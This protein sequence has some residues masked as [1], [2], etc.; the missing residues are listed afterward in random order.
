MGIISKNTNLSLAEHERWENLSDI[1]QKIESKKMQV[2]AAMIDRID[3]NIGRLLD[4]LKSKGELDNT[5]ILFA[6]DNGGSSENAEKE[7]NNVGPI[8]S[9]TNWK[10]LKKNWANVSNTPYRNYK[11]WSHE[12]GIKTPLIAY[13]PNGIKYTNS[14]IK[15]P[16]H[17]IDI[18]PTFS[19]IIDVPYPEEYNSKKIIPT[20]GK[21]FWGYLNDKDEGQRIDPL[22]WEWQHGKAV[23]L[24][25]WKLVSYKDL[26]ALYNLKEDPIEENDV[27]DQYPEIKDKLSIMY[28]NWFN[29]T[30]I[31]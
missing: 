15:T 18:L 24:G 16:V 12:G 3:Q 1:E 7:V 31:D 28:D 17:F 11:N 30:K 6:S 26:W 10:S 19:E 4:L 14:I 8:G 2:Y 5:L 27:I 21:S 23:R 22:F 25:D 9:L 20:P 13:W 29:E